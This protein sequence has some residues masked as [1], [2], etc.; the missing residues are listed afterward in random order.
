[1]LRLVKY[2][3]SFFFFNVPQMN[4]LP[5]IEGKKDKFQPHLKHSVVSSREPRCWFIIFIGPISF[6]KSFAYVFQ[7]LWELLLSKMK[8]RKHRLIS[9]SHR[10]VTGSKMSNL[11]V[12]SNRM[13]TTS[14]HFDFP[15]IFIWKYLLIRTDFD[16][17]S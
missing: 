6:T 12:L 11:P 14:H 15:L 9:V 3:N 16:K 7:I 13:P 5:A 1:M 8:K 2:L 17:W 4:N 10:Q